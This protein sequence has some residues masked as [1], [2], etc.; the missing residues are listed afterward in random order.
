MSPSQTGVTFTNTLSLESMMQNNNLMNGSGVALGDYDGDGWC[1]AYFCAIEG[2]NALFRNRGGWQ[3][4]NKTETAGVGLP[5]ARSTGAVFADT[6]GD[7]DLDLLVATLGQGVHSFINLGNGQFR[8]N[9]SEAGVASTT[10]STSMALGDIDRDGDLDLY[11]AN[12]GA[13]SVLRSG[14]RAELKKVGDQWVVTG[15]FAKRLRFVEGRLEEVGEADVL[16]L[17]D[18][19]GRFRAVP[20]GS[21]FFLD[22]Q[23]RPFPEPLD[24]GLAVQIRDL[25][26]DGWPDIYVCND[27]QSPDR[28]WI[29]DGQGRFR[30]LPLLAMRK[31]SFS[32]MGVDFADLDRDGDFDYFVTEMM[33]REH[34]RRIRQVTGNQL[35]FPR[36]GRFEN[37]PEVVRNTLFENRGDGTY[38]ELA[39]YSGVPASDWS[40]Q[41]VFLDVDLDGFE[42]LLIVNGTPFDVQDR[43]T[44]DRIRSL[45]KQSPEQSRTNLLMYPPFASANV[46]FRNQGQWRF[47]D[48]SG[49]WNFQSTAISQGIATADFD[50]D[51]D[52]DLAINCMNAPALLYKNDASAPRIGV[53]LRGIKNHFGIGAILKVFGELS[54]PQ[55]QEIL[56]GGRYLSGDDTLRVFAAGHATNRFTIEV[57]WPDGRTSRVE[58]AQANRVYRIEEP[59]MTP[60]PNTASRP[61]IAE[62][63]AP[64]GI[65]FRVSN[66]LP[67][68][69]HHEEQFNDYQR[70]PLLTK[71]MSQF[72]PGVGWIDLDAD[73]RDELLIGSGRGGKI[74]VFQQSSDGFKELP[75]ASSAIAPDDVTGVAAWHWADGAPGALL[76]L[77][78]YENA[79]NHF[80][81]LIVRMT[82]KNA[83]T[84]QGLIAGF[85]SS[86]GPLAVADMEGDGD[87][88]LFIGGRVIP[89]RYPEACDSKLFRQENGRL[90]SDDAA[91]ALLRQVGLVSGAVW[92]DLNSDGFPELILACE[93]G[94]LRLFQNH[95]GELKA[96]NPPLEWTAPRPQEPRK[97]L[98]Q[99]IGWWTSVATGDFDGDGRLDI[100]AGNWGLNDAYHADAPHPVELHYGNLGGRGQI[101]LI[102]SYYA[103]E[104][105][106]QVPRRSLTALGQALPFLI[107]KFPVH[108]AFGQAGVADI[109]DDAPIKPERVAANCLASILLLNRGTNFVALELPREAQLSP[110][111]SVN[112]A[113]ADGDGCEDVFL[114]Q[115][116]F[117]LRPE[118]PRLDAGRGLWLK[119][120]GRGGLK[121]IDGTESGVIAYGEQR[122]AALNDFNDDGRVDLVLTQNGAATLLFENVRAKP[123]LRVRL[124][125][126][127][128]NPRGIG[129]LVR[130]ES[131][132]QKGPAREMR[133]G[134]GYWSQDS[135]AQVLACAGI[136][137]SVHVLWPGGKQTTTKVPPETKSIVINTEGK[138]PE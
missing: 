104:L 12:Y 4:E 110:V 112:V 40:W 48:V 74:S 92:S 10:G 56:C 9:T 120:D 31:Q 75:W 1:D 130:I 102:E 2:T 16:Y 44:L 129:A 33:S 39:N 13:V 78:N 53:R 14:G 18:G 125:G 64:S 58:Q 35:F 57:R 15:P 94:P 34:A 7:G 26:N 137:D 5:G 8:E 89:G 30:S 69:T 98:D 49:L 71:Q 46:A 6:D 60:Q 45:G 97:T 19:Q 124:Q 136:P 62:A 52:L 99:W 28:I 105:H 127:A 41:P 70:Q 66:L 108:H 21:N 81:A 73:G 36:P 100:I 116:F 90:I 123:G 55:T 29:N 87:L 3:F 80:A 27:F 79:T 93:W 113:D 63:H 85:D 24:Y 11:V 38:A 138:I 115:N 37:R 47:T 134:S 84:G 17:N 106:K 43:D 76:G 20:W 61:T 118:W 117:A 65:Q 88:D 114:S 133:A 77:A 126:P 135:L 72:G 121:A 23:G 91:S 128:G 95:R 25:N 67:A 107:E 51:G 68:H 122:G 111:F 103:P 32:A 22:E 131:G 82:G 86:P 54:T 96:W 50:L 101:D 59:P 83:L 132:G 42:D 109:L 119:G